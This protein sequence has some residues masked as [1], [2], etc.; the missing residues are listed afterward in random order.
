MWL[1]RHR[2]VIYAVYLTIMVT[3]GVVLQILELQGIIP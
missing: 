3:V 2:K 1:Y